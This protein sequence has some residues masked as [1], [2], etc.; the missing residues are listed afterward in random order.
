[1]APDMRGHRLQRG[2]AVQD[3]PV[4]VDLPLEHDGEMGGIGDG[5]GLDDVRH[6]A[7]A[8]GGPGV[9]QGFREVEGVQHVLR[10]DGHP[11]RP[12]PGA[13]RDVE[14]GA[15]VGRGDGAG[16][17]AGIVDVVLRVDPDELHEHQVGGFGVV[18]GGDEHR[19]EGGDVVPV[20][21]ADAGRDDD[22]AAILRIR[23]RG[24]GRGQQG[25]GQGAGEQMPDGCNEHC[26]LWPDFLRGGKRFCA[27]GG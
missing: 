4:R 24:G 21:G 7:G 17:A 26:G 18:E 22:G 12:V 1:M 25:G 10:G 2:Q 23:R 6:A 19:V 27:V 15:V 5:E 20:A 9:A 16:E 13:Q 14:G 8:V 11:V 3:E